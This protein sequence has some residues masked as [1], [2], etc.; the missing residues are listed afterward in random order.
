[1]ESALNL[2]FKSLITTT[3]TAEKTHKDACSFYFKEHNFS[4]VNEFLQ[5]IFRVNRP[6]SSDRER[7]IPCK[8]SD[9]RISRCSLALTSKNVHRNKKYSTCRVVL[10]FLVT[11]VL[12]WLLEALTRYAPQPSIVFWQLKMTLLLFH[13]HLFVSFPE[14]S[15]KL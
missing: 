15:V 11:K 12:L 6:R 14:T 9:L 1:M 10:L 8:T 5:L 2:C 7:N 3:M 13:P 4:I